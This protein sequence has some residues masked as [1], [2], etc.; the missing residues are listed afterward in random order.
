MATLFRNHFAGF[1]SNGILTFSP[2]LAP[3]TMSYLSVC[4]IRVGISS[5]GYVPSAS[6]IAIHPPFATF[7]PVFN[8][9]EYP[10]FVG[11]C[12]TFIPSIESS[13]FPLL[14]LLDLQEKLA[15]D[16][17]CPVCGSLFLMD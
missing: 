3:T 16:S 2:V 1:L 7:I 4:F 14:S 13:I 15:G 8:D 10:L 6:V 11:W 17:D 9:A 12:I 5:T